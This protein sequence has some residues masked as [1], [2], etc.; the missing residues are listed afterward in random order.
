MITSL[1]CSP[2]SI[3]LSTGSKREE[4]L[5]ERKE[6]P[7]GLQ[8]L[9]GIYTD[10]WPTG[11]PRKG[12]FPLQSTNPNHSAPSA[13]DL[14]HLSSLEIVGRA[15]VELRPLRRRISDRIE[16]RVDNRRYRQ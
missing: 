2:S 11:P 8:E 1:G 7:G 6:E 9:K 14:S 3:F 13:V 5:K 12:I 16:S 10:F 15:G 4:K